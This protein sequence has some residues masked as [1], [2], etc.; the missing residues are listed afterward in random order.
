MAP[1]K[2]DG[3]NPH[4]RVFGTIMGESLDINIEEPTAGS[5]SSLWCE[6]EY[7][8]PT[9]ATG[10]PIYSMGH[11][12]EVR[13]KAPVTINGS[14]RILDLELKEHNFQS[15]PSGTV[16]TVVPRDDNNPPCAPTGCTQPKN[17]WL[18]WVWLQAS[19]GSQI[20]KQAAQSGSY[21]AGEFTGSPDST[22]LE[23]MEN[24][25]KVGGFAQGTWS[26][27]E[28]LSVTFDANCT[29]NDIDNG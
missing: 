16:T 29:V 6:R 24:T 8:V 26:A 12:S 11:N 17:M 18:Q 15:D 13:I 4:L 19:D 23:I 7:Q 9:D 14:A 5:S 28:Q 1:T 2:W 25:G 21:T 20:Y 27:T 10:N 22:G 3:A